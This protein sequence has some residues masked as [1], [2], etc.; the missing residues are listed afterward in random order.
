MDYFTKC[1]KKLFKFYNYDRRR[2][3]LPI[4]R[5]KSQFS[6]TVFFIISMYFAVFF[7]VCLKM[8]CS[9]VTFYME[10]E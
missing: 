9:S 1:A 10:V 6:I 7:S 2:D 4:H 3:L 8:S 5:H